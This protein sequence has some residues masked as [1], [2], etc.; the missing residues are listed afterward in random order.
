MRAGDATPKGPAAFAVPHAPVTD[1]PLRPGSSGESVRDVQHRL[2]GLGFGV[3]GDPSGWFGPG[4]EDAIRHFQK[5]R[6]LRVDG[7]C[8]EQTW[9]SLVEAGYRLGDRFLYVRAPMLRG[10]D[11]AHLQR[12]LG[13][14]G[15]DAGRVDGIFGPATAAALVEFQR[16]AG[17]PTDGICGTTTAAELLRLGARTPEAPTV[18]AVRE[19]EA[20]RHAP[21]SLSARRIA[22]GAPGG[23]VALAA[24]LTRVLGEA[25]AVVTV[26]QHPNESRQAVEANE[27]EAEAFVGLGVVDDPVRRVA[28]YRTEAFESVGGQRL[29]ASVLAA[30]PDDLFPEP[31]V[32]E[33]MR[34]AVLRETR[35][36]AVVCEL[37]PPPMVVEH[38]G[39]L[40]RML[41]EGI[42][43][44]LL[45]PLDQP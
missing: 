39:R 7:V 6:G 45:A 30:L 8:G 16:N 31:G 17:L 40:A 29:A 20:L 22:I 27:F 9:A 14:L 37:G 12:L 13:A 18:A 32:T 11:V 43:R 23:L 26:L 15:F 33:G 19:V 2:S 1:L 3:D 4:T 44:W 10:D 24:A 25:G 28:Y 36:P 21:Q 38:T 35:M 41:A 34:L 5:E 42:T